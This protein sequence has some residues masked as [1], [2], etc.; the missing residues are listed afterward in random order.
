[1]TPTLKVRRLTV[2]DQYHDV[3]EDDVHR[4]LVKP[5]WR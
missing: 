2:N 1:M 3:V 4:A 5:E